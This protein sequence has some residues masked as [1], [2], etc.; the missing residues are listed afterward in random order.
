M[1]VKRKELFYSVVFFTFFR[2]FMFNYWNYLDLATNLLLIVIFFF[3]VTKRI[4]TV[5]KKIDITT[6]LI[7]AMHFIILIPTIIGYGNLYRWAVTMIPPVGVAL[8]IELYRKDLRRIISV[9][10]RITVIFLIINL[11]TIMTGGIENEDWLTDYFLGSKDLFNTVFANLLTIVYLEWEFCKTKKNQ[12]KLCLIIMFI[13]IILTKSTTM[14]VEL[15]LFAVLLLFKNFRIVK[16]LFTSWSALVIYAV[17]NFLLLNATL[18]PYYWEFLDKYLEK[19]SGSMAARSRMWYAGLNI[20]SENPLFGVGKM[21][22][23]IWL[24]KVATIGFH[25]QLHNQVVEYLCT[26]GLLL[27]V[28]Y[29]IFL[30]VVG[31]QINKIRS[32]DIGFVCMIIYFVL[33]IASLSTGIY[34]A[35]YYFPF[36]LAYYLA[37]D[38]EKGIKNESVVCN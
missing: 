30:I 31:N 8:F 23:D 15:V 36:L 25:N 3:L 13:S 7:I 22:E 10:F 6:K 19:G 20:F 17:A 11:I 29:I 28:A 38:R 14:L 21:T 16:K 9:W 32:T 26:G 12:I 33:I 5:N 37:K 2:P 1:K 35:D 27:L 18:W 4:I 34:S 24:N